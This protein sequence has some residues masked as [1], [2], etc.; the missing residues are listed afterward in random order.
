M[1]AIAAM[2]LTSQACRDGTVDRLS[3]LWGNHLGAEISGQCRAGRTVTLV[4]KVP[5]ASAELAGWVPMA[6][7]LSDIR[8]A[9]ERRGGRGGA[10]LE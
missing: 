6:P 2:P 7:V 1:A 5:D 9:I 8:V 10:N 3:A 4:A